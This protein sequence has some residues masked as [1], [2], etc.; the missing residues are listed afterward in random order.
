VKERRDLT[1]DFWRN[2]VDALLN[3]QNKNVLRDAGHI[4]NKDMEARVTEV[5]D[6]FALRRKKLAAIEA[7]NADL[8]E[9]REIENEAKHRGR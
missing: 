3:F 4:S 2:N 5:Y 8:A 6:E 9:L 1:L 7:D